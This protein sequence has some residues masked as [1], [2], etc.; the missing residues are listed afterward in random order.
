MTSIID[1]AADQQ[2]KAKHRP[3]PTNCCASPVPAGPSE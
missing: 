3:W 1:Q 2:L